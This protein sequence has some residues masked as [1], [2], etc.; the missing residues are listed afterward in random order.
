MSDTFL[1]ESLTMSLVL[2]FIVCSFATI[3]FYVYIHILQTSALAFI[4]N[5]RV[6]WTLGM[7]RGNIER[8][9]FLLQVMCSFTCV[10]NFCFHLEAPAVVIANHA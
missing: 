3:L 5:H 4:G 10:F 7:V 6:N 9:A 2:S 1:A 8:I